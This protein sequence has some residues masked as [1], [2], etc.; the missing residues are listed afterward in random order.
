MH[1]KKRMMAGMLFL[2]LMVTGGCSLQD[3]E[4]EYDN[5]IFVMDYPG[6]KTED[7]VCMESAP[8]IEYEKPQAIPKLI[9]DRYGYAEEG[10]L[11]AYICAKRLPDYVY[12]IDGENRENVYR[13]KIQKVD[14][15]ESSQNYYGTFLFQVPEQGEYFLQCDYLGRSYTFRTGREIYEDL[16]DGIIEEI[17]S[18]CEK[19][20]TAA[21]KLLNLLAAYEWHP[22]IFPDEDLNGKPDV[23][24]YMAS[25]IEKNDFAGLKEE[26][27]AMCSAFF[28]KISYLY[29][30]FDYTYATE[31]LQMASSAFAKVQEAKT[32]EGDYYLALCELYRATGLAAYGKQITDYRTVITQQKILEDPAFLYGTMTYLMTRQKVDV[33]FCDLLIQKLLACGEESAINLATTDGCRQMAELNEE[34]ILEQARVL[35]CANYVLESMQYFDILKQ[36]VHYLMGQ[37][38]ESFLFFEKEENHGEYLLLIAELAALYQEVNGG[39]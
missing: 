8:V 23:L 33:S 38:A 17:T 7:I 19:D 11:T 4:K 2:T 3:G 39:S 5:S 16:F 36:T 12:V 34:E 30:Q 9:V 31:C 6:K 18:S 13:G 1:I 15:D 24:E 14:Y 25:W 37:N 27:T 29:R 10:E 22:E 21:G 26:E 28:A 20:S 35:I 32:A